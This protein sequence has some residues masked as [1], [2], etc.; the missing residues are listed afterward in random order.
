[1]ML[2]HAHSSSGSIRSA[3]HVNNSHCVLT[4]LLYLGIEARYRLMVALVLKT[5]LM[6]MMITIVSFSWHTSILSEG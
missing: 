3:M 2:S 1:M 4:K 5:Q 6:L